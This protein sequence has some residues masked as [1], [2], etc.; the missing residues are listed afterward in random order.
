VTMSEAKQQDGAKATDRKEGGKGRG[1]RKERK[2]RVELADDFVPEVGPDGKLLRME[3]PDVDGKDNKVKEL[4][5]KIDKLMEERSRIEKQQQVARAG[6]KP[7][8]DKRRELISKLK[9]LR[10]KRKALLDAAQEIKGRIDGVVS[11]NQ[12]RA[13]KD[14][15]MREQ[16]KFSNVDEVDKKIAALEEKHE[17]TAL[18]KDEE[19]AILKEISNL[20]STRRK[21]QDYLS[22]KTGGSSESDNI[23]TLKTEMKAKRTEAD[24]FKGEIE[25]LSTEL[26]KLTAENKETASKVDKLTKKR[27]ELQKQINALFGERDDVKKDFSRQWARFKKFLDALNKERDADR[28]AREEQYRKEREERERLLE[29][30]EMKKK[31]WEAEIALCD[32]L[33]AYLQNLQNPSKEKKEQVAEDNSVVERQGG[34]ADGFAGLQAVGKKSNEETDFLVMGGGKSKKNKQSKKKKSQ[35]RLMHPLDLLQSFAFLELSAPAKSE[36]IPASIKALEEKRA[37][38]DVLPRAPRKK[39]GEEAETEEDKA[40]KDPKKKSKKPAAPSV[41]SS[42]LFPVLP[43]SKEPKPAMVSPPSG[44]SAVDLVKSTGPAS[45]APV[46]ETEE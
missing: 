17:R 29:E 5:E 30:E 22:E 1:E 2:S 14:K 43:G 44:P 21:L 46:A 16:L 42:E 27:A 31:P 13:A 34:T 6:N 12:A 24:S 40:K 39:R 9:D 28:K 37:H 11:K 8:N 36:D 32:Q 33:I 19:K 38:F 3:R 26:D 10:G 18:S 23:P 35:G 41:E 15:Q 25:S 20:K 4:T 45:P 7:F